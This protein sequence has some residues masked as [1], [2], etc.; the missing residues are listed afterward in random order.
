MLSVAFGQWSASHDSRDCDIARDAAR[1][2]T[3]NTRVIQGTFS[4]ASLRGGLFLFRSNHVH[5]IITYVM[6]TLYK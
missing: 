5:F 1:E 3:E 2:R 4:L 6:Q